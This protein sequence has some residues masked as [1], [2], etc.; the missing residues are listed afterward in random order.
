MS[1]S[2]S[3][4]VRRTAGP[5]VVLMLAA[6]AAGAFT[7]PAAA[8]RARAPTTTQVSVPGAGAPGTGFSFENAV[9]ADGRYVAFGSTV[10]TLVPGDTN[11]EGDVF[12]RDLRAGTTE[13]ISVSGTGAQGDGNSFHPAVSADGR[14]VAFASLARTLVDGE[15]GDGRANVFVRDR[16]T[17]TTTKV[18]RAATGG[19]TDGGSTDTA[20]S[21]DGRYVAFGSDATN[22]VA[23]DTNGVRDVFRHDRRTGATVRVSVA[24][25]GVQGD[26]ASLDPEISDDGRHVTYYSTATNLTPGDTN[27]VPDVFVRDLRAGATT[28]VSVPAVSGGTSGW[29]AFTPDISADGRRVAFMST[30]NNLVAGDTNNNSD[31][32]VRDLRAGTTTL[33]SVSGGGQQ[34]AAGAETPAIS[35]DGRHVVFISA[36]GALVPGDTNQVGD[37][38]R[39]DLRAGTT[40]RVSVSSTGTQADDG[41]QSPTLNAD[42]TRVAFA[43]LATNLVAGDRNGQI[44]VFVHIRR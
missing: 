2:T 14:Y 10:A 4:R 25:D 15:P 41:S 33:V 42:G 32:F 24:G 3:P 44:D 16:R 31:I 26:D 9:S 37:V 21:G 39:R 20:I 13:R 22:L 1:G 40:A 35:A 19:A 8:G 27:E 30:G 5:A 23:G 17:G 12:L 7:G 6:A 18:T 36:D 34:V 11:D 38:F 43:S 29:G 28:L